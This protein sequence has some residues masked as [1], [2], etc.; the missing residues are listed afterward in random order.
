MDMGVAKMGQVVFSGA[1]L[2]ELRCL[3]LGSCIGLVL[4]DPT[5][6]LGCMAHVVLPEARPS[7][8]AE[9][10]KYADTAVPYVVAEM[11]RKGASKGRLRAA[12]V[13]GA[14][15]FSFEGASETMDVGRRNIAAVKKHLL[16]MKIRL[17]AEDVGGKLGRTVV[18][19][20]GTGDVTVRQ[21]GVPEKKL[22]NLLS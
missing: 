19:D 2:Q 14:Q 3:G 10:A 7:S 13:G 5:L 11:V 22:T 17:V 18:L 15:L 4:V 6:K 16:D 20:A 1:E 12:I 9:P 8:T 21:S